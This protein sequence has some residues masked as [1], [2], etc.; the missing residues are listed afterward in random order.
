MNY[1]NQKKGRKV[2]KLRSGFPA[3]L[4]AASKTNTERNN[5]ACRTARRVSFIVYS[6]VISRLAGMMHT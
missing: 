5:P 1:G 6:T 3:F 2:L 4:R